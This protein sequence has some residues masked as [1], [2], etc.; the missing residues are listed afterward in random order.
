MA[1]RSF[2]LRTARRSSA[3]ASSGACIGSVA[4]PRKRSGCAATSLAIW[5]F[6]MAAHAAVNA[7]SWS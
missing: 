1:P 6:W 7:G 5:S 4:M 3:A 2:K